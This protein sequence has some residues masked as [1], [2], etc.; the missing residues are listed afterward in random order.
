MTTHPVCFEVDWQLTDGP[1]RVGPPSPG[2]RAAH[3]DLE[4]VLVDN[5]EN[6]AGFARQL[7]D[8]DTAAIVSCRETFLLVQSADPPAA[9]LR[10]GAVVAMHPSFGCARGTGVELLLSGRLRWCRS[11]PPTGFAD[12][13]LIAFP[14]LARSGQLVLLAR[15]H[16]R[17]SE[18][19]LRAAATYLAQA[20]RAPVRGQAPFTM[21]R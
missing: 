20:G 19:N 13:A 9:S 17:L 21:A 18:R 14:A 7:A 16:G 4:P 8:A 10:P 5:A 6:E 3:E 12:A 11:S 1:G 2:P 15:C